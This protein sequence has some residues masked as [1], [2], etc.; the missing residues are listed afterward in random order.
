M[1]EEKMARGLSLAREKERDGDC[2]NTGY[3]E[4][5][6]GC[7]HPQW[8]RSLCPIGAFGKYDTCCTKCKGADVPH[9]K[10][11]KSVEA[12]RTELVVSYS[13]HPHQSGRS[14]IESERE[15][16]ERTTEEQAGSIGGVMDT[17][18]DFS[19]Y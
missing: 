8:I 7:G 10:M 14:T 15:M 13:A 1:T 17:D 5:V 4:C 6:N 12:D 2:C 19:L 11:C 16:A 18:A 3:K 9:F